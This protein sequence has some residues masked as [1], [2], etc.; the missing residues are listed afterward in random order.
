MEKQLLMVLNLDKEMIKED[1]FLTN[2]PKYKNKLPKNQHLES[3]ILLLKLNYPSI[4]YD[5]IIHVVLYIFLQL[6]S[7]HEKMQSDYLWVRHAPIEEGVK[8]RLLLPY[9]DIMVNTI[10]MNEHL[11][12]HSD[13]K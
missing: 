3:K 9:L 1:S 6:M 10:Y 4:Y 7:I 8:V 13:Y 5:I 2:Q 12:Q 11:M